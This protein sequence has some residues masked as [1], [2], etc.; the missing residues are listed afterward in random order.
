MKGEL[1]V[2]KSTLVAGGVA[3]ALAA[4]AVQG[5][6]ARLEEIV[7]TA[8]KR[9]ANIQEVPIA[10]S[11]FSGEDLEKI[12]ALTMSDVASNTPNL[13]YYDGNTLS[14]STIIR[15]I[16][17]ISGSPG[18]DPTVGY[19][20]DEGYLGGGVSS[21]LDL[22]DIERIEVLRGPQG[23]LFGRNTI[24]GVINI[25][26]KRPP[27]EFGGYAEA[28]FGDY[29]HTR[30]RGSVGGPLLEGKLSASATAMYFD[31]DGTLDN[32]YLNKDVNNIHEWGART[33]FLYTPSDRSE[34][35]F[36]FDYRDVDQTA[37]TYET[38]INDMD[39]IPGLF[40][41]LLNDDPYDR[42]VF[43][44][45]EGAET[46]EAW[47]ALLRGV[48]NYD[49]FDFVTVTNY[50]THD[51]FNSGESDLAPIAIGRNNDP[52]EVERFT[53]EFR[54]SSTGEGKLNWD[55]GVYYYHLDSLS[56][57]QI[58]LE[59]DF[60]AIL[61][62]PYTYMMKETIGDMTADSYA[63][64]ASFNYEF[65]DRFDVTFGARYT[66]E[67]KSIDYDQQDFEAELGF[68]ILGGTVAYQDED[69]WDQ[70][71]PALTLRYRFDGDTMAFAT[72]SEGFKSGGYNDGAGDV[73]GISFGP[74]TLWN[75]E[76]GFKTEFADGRV[77]FNASVFYMDWDDMQLRVDDP[78][79][80]NSFDP[81]I[82]NA[83]K[84]HST[85]AEFELE[86]IVA[87]G[88]TLGGH[89]GLLDGQFD[90]GSL[91]DG[92]PLD[93]LVGAADFSGAVYGEYT[94]PLG[95]NL[96]LF[97]RG[98]VVFT[99]SYWM[100]A[101]QTIPEAEQDGYELL[102]ARIMLSGADD[103]WHVA[104]W[105]K[106]LTDEAYN[107]GVFDLLTNPFV[108]QYFNEIGAPRTYGVEVRL[109]F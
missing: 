78:N 58:E 73:S 105:G 42:K 9:E 13:V 97:I 12:D 74:E 56:A 104:L 63:A 57:G 34:W 66:Y 85:G 61:G 102:N 48:I 3:L 75:Y 70:F 28:E 83:G 35:L 14:N 36:T 95:G 62:Y 50:R 6:E 96:N 91:P 31:R 20:V 23:T 11:A 94:T 37:K 16:A 100:A 39:S 40:G 54:L 41:S 30:L 27:S 76:A 89:L 86:A 99:D 55:V 10:I 82:L 65:N 43:A 98:D 80:P 19:Y 17:P 77:R 2:R 33:S 103:R 88:L 45:Y 52:E 59:E 32:V 4:S 109:N 44:G 108:G 7:V 51:Y 25:T 22:Y 93:R 106:N 15:G 79:T 71:T 60:F 107:I 38:L 24:G 29:N 46:L 81:R 87:K 90:E 26:T 5:Q 18:S 21:S 84:A 68:P 69:S 64:F 72:V 53:Q 8:Q 67:E 92:T 1:G 49:R 101:N 47:G